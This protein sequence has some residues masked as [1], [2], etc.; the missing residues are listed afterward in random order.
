MSVKR[1]EH[2]RREAEEAVLQG[3]A[4]HMAEVIDAALSAAEEENL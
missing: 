2:D 1:G 3:H 4:R